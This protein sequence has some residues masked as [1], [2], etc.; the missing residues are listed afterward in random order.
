MIEITI[1]ERLKNRYTAASGGILFI[2]NIKNSDPGKI[3]EKAK[4][5]TEADLVRRFSD[6]PREE[7]NQNPVLEAYRAYFKKFKKTYHI[8][9]QLESVAKK[10]RSFPAVNPLVDSCFLAELNTFVLSAGH[11][12]DLLSS[13]VQFDLSTDSDDFVQIN[14]TSITLKSDDIIMKSGGKNVCSVIYGQDKSSA[15]SPSTENAFFVS[16]APE[17]VPE[18]PLIENLDLIEFY[19][20]QFCP[21]SETV[22]KKI[23]S[24]GRDFI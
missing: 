15:L 13:A 6:I 17:G 11:D 23:F 2:K 12:A 4:T 21:A 19:V 1:T 14:G 8:L 20:K 16:Y 18:K 7:L 24:F 10:G 3:L 5:E 9:L 22:L